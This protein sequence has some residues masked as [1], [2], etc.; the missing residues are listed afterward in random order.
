MFNLLKS[1]FS[2]RKEKLPTNSLV[3]FWNRRTTN[4][5]FSVVLLSKSTNRHLSSGGVHELIVLKV[6]TELA[7]FSTHRFNY[8]NIL[9]DVSMS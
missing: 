3:I 7:K 6:S 5:Q 9:Q 1:A 2:E 8:P 4:I